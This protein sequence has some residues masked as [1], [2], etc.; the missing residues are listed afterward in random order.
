MKTQEEA[1]ELSGIMKEIGNLANR[2]TICILTNMEEPV[3]KCVGNSLE[4][5]E[6]IECLKGNIP[7]DIK[8]IILTLGSY[9]IKL[10]GKGDNLEE[11]KKKILENIE[12]GKAY[13][14]FLEIVE[15]HGGDVEYIEN[16]SKFTEAKYILPV[17]SEKEG[18][19]EKLDGEK[20]GQIS[21]NIGAGR[22]KKEDNIY[23]EVG[24]VLNK[25][26]SDK[27]EMGDILAYIHANNK[28][29]GTK[30]VEDLLNAYTVGAHNCDLQKP[31]HIL[32]IIE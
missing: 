28:E 3:G 6:S 20:V 5:I 15:E 16:T 31:K 13:S 18:Y 4:I 1:I 26:T 14:K 12:N 32:G 29:D 21:V 11:N 7:E 9:I 30:A 10:D 22:I 19:V 17:I 25:K 24:I 8:E 2:E 27:V 23:P